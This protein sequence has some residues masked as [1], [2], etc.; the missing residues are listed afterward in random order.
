MSYDDFGIPEDAYVP[1]PPEGAEYAA[2]CSLSSQD[3]LVGYALITVR[4]WT[5]RERGRPQESRPIPE[6]LIEWVTGDH[7]TS[8]EDGILIEEAQESDG[9]PSLVEGKLLWRGVMYDVA[10]LPWPLAQPIFKKYFA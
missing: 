3:E 8:F 2:V 7:P 6:A 5:H 10:W 1:S 9:A 4:I